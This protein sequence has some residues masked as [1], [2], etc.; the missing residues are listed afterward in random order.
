M[1]ITCWKLRDHKDKGQDKTKMKIRVKFNTC[2]FI[3]N[4]AEARLIELNDRATV[5][6]K[7]NWDALYTYLKEI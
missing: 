4:S 5:N 1:L 3:G 7:I 6:R 2:F